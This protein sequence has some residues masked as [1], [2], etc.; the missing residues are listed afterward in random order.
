MLSLFQDILIVVSTVVGSLLFMA[1]VNRV[2]PWEK[3]RSHNDLI[4]W[5]LTVL[6]TAYAVILGWRAEKRPQSSPRALGSAVPPLLL[7][8]CNE[9]PP[10]GQDTIHYL[11]V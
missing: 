4:G 8:C 11:S 5:Q 1:I 9:S 10:P 6:G 3:R 2:W 7:R